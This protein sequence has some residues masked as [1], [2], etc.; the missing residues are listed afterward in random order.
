MDSRVQ[1]P[2]KIDV[3]IWEIIEEYFSNKK[4]SKS[5]KNINQQNNVS[6]RYQ[7]DQSNHQYDKSRVSKTAESARNGDSRY[8]N[9][10]IAKFYNFDAKNAGI[11]DLHK[12]N[13]QI[14]F[15]SFFLYA[16]CSMPYAK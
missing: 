8:Y 11:E 2:T 5:F 3:S 13:Q 16:L 4:P 14:R 1:R 10:A 12:Q 9:D 7:G 15:R 6:K